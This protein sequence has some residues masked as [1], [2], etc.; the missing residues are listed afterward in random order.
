M[1]NAA[2]LI[3]NLESSACYFPTLRGRFVLD[4]TRRL[5]LDI[6]QRAGWGSPT[7]FLLD[8]LGMD[9]P[10]AFPEAPIDPSTLKDSDPF[11]S[12]LLHAEFCE[13]HFGR[14]LLDGIDRDSPVL[15]SDF[16]LDGLVH[17]M[18]DHRGFSYEFFAEPEFLFFPTA[19]ERH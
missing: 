8:A 15:H 13:S 14:D 4:L 9:V 18:A 6:D 11:R 17:R 19:P 7:R 3:R 1:L 16:P 5:L 10:A 12:N 2:G